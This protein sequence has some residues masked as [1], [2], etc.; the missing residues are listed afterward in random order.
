MLRKQLTHFGHTVIEGRN[1]KEGL[2]LGGLAEFGFGGDGKVGTMKTC[3][4]DCGVRH[5]QSRENVGAGA[6]VRG[7]RE[8]DAWD[9]R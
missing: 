4:K 6:R 8:G 9:A 5:G 2:E 1:G 7:S 3:G